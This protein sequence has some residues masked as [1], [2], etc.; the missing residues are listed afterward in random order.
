MKM[1]AINLIYLHP[2][3]YRTTNL[4]TLYL[5]IYSTNILTE[6]FKHAAHSPFFFLQDAVYFIMLPFFG[7]CNTQILN[8][9][10]A[11]NFKENSGAKWL[12]N[13]KINE[14][15]QF[16][17]HSLR[18]ITCILDTTSI[19]NQNSNPTPRIMYMSGCICMV[20]NVM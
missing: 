14:L 7:S 10:C 17:Q 11:K 19:N 6:Y 4:Q 9:G 18:Q 8:T 16:F 15:R 1:S 20:N 2:L 13:V 12:K 5:N 3:S